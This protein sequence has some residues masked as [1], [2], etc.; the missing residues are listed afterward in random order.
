MR[1]FLLF[2]SVPICT[3]FAVV[4]VPFSLAALLGWLLGACS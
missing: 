1:D 4:V 3:F 2:F